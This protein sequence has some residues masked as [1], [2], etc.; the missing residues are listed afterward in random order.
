MSSILRWKN[1][2]DRLTQAL[3]RDRIMAEL[4]P[5][6]SKGVTYNGIQI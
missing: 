2:S 3:K 6:N 5:I 4:S 1:L